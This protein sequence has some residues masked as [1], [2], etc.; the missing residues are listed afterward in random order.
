MDPSVSN[1]I[2]NAYQTQSKNGTGMRENGDTLTM[3]DFLTLL[4][5]Q[6]QNQDMNEPMNNAEMM[7]QMVQMATV[8]AMSTMSAQATTSYAAG[9]MGQKV[10]V[11]TIGEDGKPTSVSGTV[12]GVNLSTTEPY[13]YLDGGTTGY[14]LKSIMFV[15]DT[16]VEEGDDADKGDS[17]NT[18]DEG[19]KNTPDE[20]VK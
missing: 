7:N 6:L 15:G 14:S 16:P 3:D 9:M 4:I 17:G 8:E 13:I 2:A 20:P 12:T 19:D 10:E 5:T 11:L 1:K 18:P